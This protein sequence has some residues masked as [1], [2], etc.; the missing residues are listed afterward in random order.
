M[1]LIIGFVA[2]VAVTVFL[3]RK[4]SSKKSSSGG[5]GVGGFSKEPDSQG[6]NKRK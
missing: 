3:L 2:I 1:E 4:R 5:A 6:T